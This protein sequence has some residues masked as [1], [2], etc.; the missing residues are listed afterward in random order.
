MWR[1]EVFHALSVHF[2]IVLLLL[3]TILFL[4]ALWW[5]KKENAAFLLPASRL[6][7]WLGVVS[8]WVAIYTGDQAGSAVTR[9]LCDPTTLKQHEIH[10]YWVG[11]IFTSGVLLEMPVLARQMKHIAIN[12]LMP[13]ICCALF[14]LG[15]G[16][17]IYVGH[18][19]ASLVYQ[20]GAGVY[21]PSADC[22]EF[23]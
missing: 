16:Y 10:A 12:R 3:G 17:M 11:Y 22:H 15:T 5:K 9:Q 20:Q 23:N 19:G 2:P 7:L 14:I 8:V 21:H 4:L 13:I 18:L 6:L 1:I